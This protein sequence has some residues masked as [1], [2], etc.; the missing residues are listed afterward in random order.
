M[1]NSKPD[2]AAFLKALMD[3]DG[4]ITAFSMLAN[5][6]RTKHDNTDA[7]P[8][9]HEWMGKA[10]FLAEEAR[11]ARSQNKTIT[12]SRLHLGALTALKRA[13]D[14]T[15]DNTAAISDIFNAS[16]KA[17]DAADGDDASVD[18]ATVRDDAVKTLRD[19][20]NDEYVPHTVRADIAK[21]VIESR[22]G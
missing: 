14:T 7:T 5:L 13:L 8:E 12:S 9:F 22:I 21:Y 19:L 17:E 20:M 3:P 18:N 1:T 2:T 15:S 6:V 10:E 4:G 16:V 11:R